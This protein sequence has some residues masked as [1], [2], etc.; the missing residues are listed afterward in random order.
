MGQEI[1]E[2]VMRRGMCLARCLKWRGWIAD[3]GT[4]T[5]DGDFY[6]PEFIRFLLKRDQKILLKLRVMR[7]TGEYPRDN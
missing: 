1:A 4:T 3:G 6:S 2:Y 7:V 5:L